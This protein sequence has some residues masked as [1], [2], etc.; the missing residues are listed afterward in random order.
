M[1]ALFIG[2][3]ETE[4]L[5]PR[6]ASRPAGHSDL[7]LASQAGGAGDQ[8]ATGALL[9]NEKNTPDLFGC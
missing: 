6:A 1:R 7:P 2:T 8:E 3:L 9:A 4:A 5:A